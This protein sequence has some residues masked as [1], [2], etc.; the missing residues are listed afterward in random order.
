[1]WIEG[2]VLE[3][4]VNHI[5]AL[6]MCESMLCAP[7]CLIYYCAG[8]LVVF[9]CI[10]YNNMINHYSNPCLLSHKPLILGD[11]VSSIMIASNTRMDNRI[12]SIDIKYHYIKDEVASKRVQLQHVASEYNVADI[13]TKPLNS[14]K[15]HNF[16]NQILGEL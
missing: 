10:V 4:C 6:T 13:F 2:G 14:V 8:L 11:N 9:M 1:M 15:F 5:L 3:L 7:A 16:K 12:K